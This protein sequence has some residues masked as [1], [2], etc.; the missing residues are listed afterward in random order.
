MIRSILAGLVA[1]PQ[2]LGAGALVIGLAGV[3]LI[4]WIKIADLQHGLAAAE[5][6]LA[7]ERAQLESCRADVERQ[8][9]AVQ[10][11]ADGA[12][13]ASERAASR[14]RRELA[15]PRRQEPHG[16]PSSMEAWIVGGQ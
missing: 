2:L 14:A 5:L 6:A 13:L 1:R 15:K 10:R 4:V 12:K 11:M 9:A 7:Q 8:N 3:A 16:D